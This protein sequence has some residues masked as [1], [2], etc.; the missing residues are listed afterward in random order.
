MTSTGTS[1]ITVGF[2]SSVSA[3]PTGLAAQEFAASGTSP[4][5]GID[6]GGGISNASSATVTFPKLTPKSSGEVYFAFAA[7]ANTASAGTTRVSPTPHL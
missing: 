4:V 7:V 6:T 5:W 2:S 1:T 3:V